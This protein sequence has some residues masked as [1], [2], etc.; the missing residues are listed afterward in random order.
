MERQVTLLTKGY[1]AYQVIENHKAAS[2]V[3]LKREELLVSGDDWWLAVVR[4]I[5]P[6]L[7]SSSRAEYRLILRH[8]KFD[9]R[10]RWGAR[11]DLWM[12]NAGS[13]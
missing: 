3:D 7:F 1:R 5:E 10:L 2:W 13:F 12:M 8:D 4:T 11:L 9:M 6:Y